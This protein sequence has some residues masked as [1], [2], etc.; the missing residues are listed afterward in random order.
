M[1]GKQNFPTLMAKVVVCIIQIF[2]KLCK[3]I[4]LEMLIAVSN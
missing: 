3:K 4:N 1:C 2:L